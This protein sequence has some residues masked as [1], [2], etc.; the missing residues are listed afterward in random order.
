[1]TV[2]GLSKK[3][4]IKDL[5]EFVKGKIWGS[6]TS[7]RTVATYISDMPDIT[8]QDISGAVYTSHQRY[9]INLMPTTY[10]LGI[11]PTFEDFISAAQN[12]AHTKIAGI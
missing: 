12:M 3:A 5:S 9:G 2:S 11:A 7:G 1:M 8:V 10:K 6:D 4:P